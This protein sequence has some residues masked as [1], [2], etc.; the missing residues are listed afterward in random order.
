MHLHEREIQDQNIIEEILLEGKY[1]VIAM[2]RD[3]QPYLVTLNYGYDASRETLYFH[4]APT[5][6][7]M[8]ILRNNPLVCA[9][10]IRDNGYVTGK[11]AHA[12]R[13]VVMYGRMDTVDDPD[14]KKH[15]MQR[16]LHQ[17]ESE[18]QKMEE[19]LLTRDKFIKQTTMLKLKIDHKRGKE[20]Q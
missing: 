5:G 3:H 6:L 1:A 9:T 7:K 8:D 15:G 18:P 12:Y 17:L 20:G 4:S 14:E 16:M 13:S 2:C 10:V 19:R 11:C